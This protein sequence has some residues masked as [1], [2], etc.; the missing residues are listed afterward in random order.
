M[1]SG[2]SACIYC[3]S[4]TQTPSQIDYNQCYKIGGTDN[5]R[6]AGTFYTFANWQAAGYDNHG[7]WGDPLFVDL[8]E[9]PYDLSPMA[10][11]YAINHGVD[12]SGDFTSDI[13]G[14]ERSGTWDI[15][16]YEY[17][18]AADVVAP[19]SPTGLAVS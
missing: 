6:I 8:V 10:S 15:G 11:S 2:A 5:Y 16:A 1:G 12:L 13:L 17:V 7:H 19:A 18:G 14:N 3:A 9:Y 4:A